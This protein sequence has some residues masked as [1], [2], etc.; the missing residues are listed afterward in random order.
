MGRWGL[1][2]L[3]ALIAIS[4]LVYVADWIVL[5][6]RSG[7]A[8]GSIVVNNSYVIHQKNGKMEYLYD[9]PQPTPCVRSLF[10]HQ[11]QTACWWLARHT[12]PQKD[13]TAN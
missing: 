12:E 9:P 4:A 2:M 13:I 10:P 1:K 8:H 11:S 6:A 7:S 5:Q 3:V